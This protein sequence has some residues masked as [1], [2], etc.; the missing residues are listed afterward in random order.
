VEES[1]AEGQQPETEK[2]DPAEADAKQ[3][4]KT[5]QG[6]KKPGV[7]PAAGPDIKWDG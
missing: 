7:P 5:G 6:G 2:T 3:A 4:E 1:K